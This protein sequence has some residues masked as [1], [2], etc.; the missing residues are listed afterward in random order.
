MA[1]RLVFGKK[2]TNFAEHLV[3]NTFYRGLLLIV[4]FLLLPVL[5]ICERNGTP[6]LKNYAFLTQLI[7]LVLMYWC[8]AQFFNKIPAIKSLA[9][10]LLTFLIMTAINVGIGYL[11]WTVASIV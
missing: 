7:D 3:L 11:A 8:Y 2:G 5:Y 10:T 1:S 4:S 9:L 6:G